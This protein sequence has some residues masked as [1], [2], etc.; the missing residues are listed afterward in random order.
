MLRRSNPFTIS[1]TRSSM[2]VSYSSCDVVLPKNVKLELGVTIFQTL[3][4]YFSKGF[5]SA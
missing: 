3:E 1:N 2:K 4:F 5:V